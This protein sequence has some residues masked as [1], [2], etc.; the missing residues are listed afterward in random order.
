[1]APWWLQVITVLLLSFVLLSFL[2]CLSLGHV[3]VCLR[4]GLRLNIIIFVIALS[5]EDLTCLLS[6]LL[7]QFFLKLLLLELTHTRRVNIGQEGLF[8]LLFRLEQSAI[9]SDFLRLHILVHR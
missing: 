2:V 3:S 8:R 1:M 5:A 4:S 6:H 7:L 9:T